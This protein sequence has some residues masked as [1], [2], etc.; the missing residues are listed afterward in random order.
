MDSVSELES[1]RWRIEPS[2]KSP[3]LESGTI[4]FAMEAGMIDPATDPAATESASSSKAVLSSAGM[5]PGI[6]R[7]VV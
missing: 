1:K 4:E 3:G 2:S 5:S 6:V 7:V